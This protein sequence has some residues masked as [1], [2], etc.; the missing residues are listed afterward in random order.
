MHFLV[1]D[2]HFFFYKISSAIVA[3]TCQKHRPR[4][5]TFNLSKATLT[6]HFTAINK[7]PKIAEP[8]S[9]CGPPNFP[10][11]IRFICLGNVL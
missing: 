8:H 7:W 1:L 9:T 6:K 3:L 11:L 4:K 5:Q 2:I 10:H